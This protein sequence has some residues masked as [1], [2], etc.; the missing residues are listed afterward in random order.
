[1]A[2]GCAVSSKF[3]PSHTKLLQ[4]KNYHSHFHK[5]LLT[6]ISTSFISL[7]E[8]EYLVCLVN[9]RGTFFSPST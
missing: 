1:M 8:R 6:T 2:G 9:L 4:E 3:L 5:S 7:S